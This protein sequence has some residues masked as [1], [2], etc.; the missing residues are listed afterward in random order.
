MI[1]RHTS[2]P[3]PRRQ[4][5]TLT[6]LALA[7]TV[8]PA[9]AVAPAV[10]TR[11]AVAHELVDGTGGRESLAGKVVLT[12]PRSWTRTSNDTAPTATFRLLIASGC[13]AVAQVS[14]RAVA[15]RSSAATRV[16]AVTGYSRAVLSDRRRPGGWLRLV[17]LD[18]NARLGLRAYGIAAVTIGTAR[19]ID[20]RAFVRFSGCT[21]HQVRTRAAGS[22]LRSLLVTARPLVRIVRR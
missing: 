10:T 14:V 16:R 5:L 18:G 15:S 11:I 4:L 7:A 20:V 13:S 3:M 1:A 12:T 19:W 22:G 6:L 21:D 2:R 8:A 9:L 17:Q